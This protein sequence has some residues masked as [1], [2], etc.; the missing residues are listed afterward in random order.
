MTGSLLAHSGGGGAI[1]CLLWGEGRAVPRG[2]S[3][4]WL[5]LLADPLSVVCWGRVRHAA[6]A[7]GSSKVAVG[8]F[9]SFSSFPQNLLQIL[10]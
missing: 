4:G 3:E 1:W 6:F 7:L 9:I 10:N 2:Q 5:R 8:F